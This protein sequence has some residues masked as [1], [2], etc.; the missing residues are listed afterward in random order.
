MKGMSL[1]MNFI[2]LL[3]VI[4]LTVL[5]GCSNGNDTNP[6][7]TNEYT[8]TFTSAGASLNYSQI[9]V[10]IEV[11]AGAV[12][13]GVTVPLSVTVQPINLPERAVADSIFE[14]IGWISLENKGNPDIVLQK[15]I[16]VCFPLNG[17]FKSNQNFFVFRF[18][19][20]SGKWVT[21]GR[22]AT[23]TD[24][25]KYAIFS[26]DRF[27]AWGVFQIVPLRVDATASRTIAKAPASI[28]LTAVI[29]GGAPPYTVTWWYGDDNDP[30]VGLSI[31][32][33]YELPMTYTPCCIVVDSLG[34]E[35]SDYID[36]NLY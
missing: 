16:T 19:R 18:D 22:Q 36:I 8:L 27:G 7:P 35:A 33:Y 23:V 31:S 12:E 24:T 10:Q 1:N 17:S 26:A 34:H 14:R 21:D 32:H 5:F 20:K 6:L 13:E 3:T 15:G 11:P 25:G 30:D 9:G 29:D 2:R 4:G 28:T